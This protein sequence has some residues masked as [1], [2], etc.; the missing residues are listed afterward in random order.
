[1]LCMF[2]NTFSGLKTEN[3]VI[4]AFGHFFMR[5]KLMQISQQC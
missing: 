4:K 3:F 2:Y 5:M 1:M